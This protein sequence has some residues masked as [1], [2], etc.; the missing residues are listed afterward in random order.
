MMQ[1]SNTPILT[2][3]ALKQNAVQLQSVCKRALKRIRKKIEN[4]EKDQ[5]EAGKFAWYS[6]IGDSIVAHPDAVRRGAS[7]A[8]IQNIHTQA[9][10]EITLDPG[11]TVFENAQELYKR[12]RKGK[13]GLE[14]VTELIRRARA[15]EADTAG[16]FEVAQRLVEGENAT[17]DPFSASVAALRSKLVERG[18]LPR[19]REAA[20]GRSPEEYVPYRRLTLDGW[21]IFIGKNDAQNDELSTRFAKPWDIWMHVAAHAG[22]HVV[23]R[24]DKNAQWPPRDLLLKVASFA[25]WFSKAKHTSYAEVHVTEARFVRK[26]RHAPPGEVIAERCKTLR[27]SPKSPQEFF[28]GDFDK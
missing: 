19:Q 10:E 5:E 24:R 21:N 27:V 14:T 23:I 2:V 26:R 6:Q 25:V 13:R 12:A 16:L 17:L 11:M 15:E 1:E 9:M 7:A 3:E 20:K 4:L 28:P 18:V 22:S 8:I